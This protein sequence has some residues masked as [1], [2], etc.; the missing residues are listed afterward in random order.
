[1]MSIFLVNAVLIMI[2]LG[3]GVIQAF[4]KNL[5][6]WETPAG[7]WAMFLTVLQLLL[8]VFVPLI[9]GMFL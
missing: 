5:Y 4:P 8:A 9:G 7:R 3:I 2:L 1:M 6:P